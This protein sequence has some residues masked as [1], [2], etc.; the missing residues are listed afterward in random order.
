M[1]RTVLNGEWI[2]NR[3]PNWTLASCQG[4]LKCPLYNNYAFHYQMR[5]ITLSSFCCQEDISRRVWGFHG[6]PYNKANIGHTDWVLMT[7]L[8]WLD[9]DMP[10]ASWSYQPHRQMYSL[11]ALAILN[12]VVSLASDKILLETWFWFSRNLV[13]R[14][15]RRTDTCNNAVIQGCARH[16][17]WVSRRVKWMMWP[18]LPGRSCKGWC[19][20]PRSSV[21]VESAVGW[22]KSLRE[23]TWR[24]E[25]NF[26]KRKQDMYK[27]AHSI[28]EPIQNLLSGPAGLL[29]IK[30]L[31]R[32]TT[33][34]GLQILPKVFRTYLVVGRKPLNN[35]MRWSKTL[36]TE[37]AHGR[38]PRHEGSLCQGVFRGW[39]T[40]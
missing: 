20:W 5:Q 39:M 22:R 28:L 3:S 16:N 40:L 37:L 36:T 14:S 32:A 6:A 26:G 7:L 15:G 23:T 29:Q 11:Y 34:K 19:V 25:R 2:R 21:G 18:G 31:A 12:W 27:L 24:Q 1:P 38:N 30:S 8:K 17:E 9:P 33:L 4:S 35:L 13:V 10:E